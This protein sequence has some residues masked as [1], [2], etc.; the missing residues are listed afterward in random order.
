MIEEF[1]K[2]K[3]L[4]IYKYLRLGRL[5]EEKTI[6]LNFQGKIPGSLHP[7]IGME[8]IGVGVSLALEK[9]DVALKTHR[10]HA[11]M[12]AEGM[13][14][15]YMF[16]E[17]MGKSNGYDKGKGGSMHL[18]GISA[19]LGSNTHIA[20]GAALAFKLRNEKRVAI[21]Y[22]GDGAANQGPVH[23]AMNMAAIWKLPVVFVLENNEYAVTTPI[24]YSILIKNLS[25]RAKAYG[26]SGITIDGMDV[27]EIYKTAKALIK[28]ARI[29]EGPSLMECKTYRY[30]C[31]S[32]GTEKLKL[33]YRTNEEIKNWKLKDPINLWAKKLLEE[34]ICVSSEL[35]EIDS[36]AEDLIEESVDCAINSNWPEPEEAFKDMYATKYSGIPQR[37]W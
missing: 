24:N 22:L 23:E 35:K 25:E 7:A 36:I 28:R 1:S 30:C 5:F 10:G 4:E 3:C 9:G 12:I 11:A 34:N 18:A 37:G 2:D 8:A 31:H 27:L 26:F 19:V 16:A 15:K 29:G 21:G 13:E 6:E 17:L 20:S 32:V 14:M 33:N